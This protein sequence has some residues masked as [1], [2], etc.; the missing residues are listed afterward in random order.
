M[1]AIWMGQRILL[2]KVLFFHIAKIYFGM[3]YWME[4][5]MQK[6]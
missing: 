5:M 4:Q 2:E 6:N 1:Q 3:N